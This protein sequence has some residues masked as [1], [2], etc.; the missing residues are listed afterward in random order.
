MNLDLAEKIVALL[1]EY[2]VSE[3]A[4]QT[5]KGPW[6]T[7]RRNLAPP[8]KL[9]GSVTKSGCFPRQWWVSF[10]TLSRRCF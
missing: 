5:E 4:V 3:I 8:K 2:P 7:R 9:R 1:G 6:Q 10:T